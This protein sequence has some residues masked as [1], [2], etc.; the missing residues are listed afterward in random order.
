MVQA[1]ECNQWDAIYEVPS[2]FCDP[3]D[4]VAWDPIMW[5]RIVWSRNAELRAPR[6]LSGPKANAS[7]HKRGY[8]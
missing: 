4:P 5:D 2:M 3:S 8:P 1:M 7:D 6:Q